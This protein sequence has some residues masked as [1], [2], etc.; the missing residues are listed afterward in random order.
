MHT[1]QRISVLPAKFVS[2]SGMRV[3]F[4]ALVRLSTIVLLA[5]GTQASAHATCSNTTLT[6]D[7]ASTV[8]G[9]FSTQTAQWKPARGWLWPTLM[10]M[11]ISRKQ[12]SS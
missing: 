7:Y 9:S 4:L 8:S 12:T 2:G 11:A 10:A 3:L 6:G 1:L 5:A